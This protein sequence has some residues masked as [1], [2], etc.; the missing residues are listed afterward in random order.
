MKI[1]QIFSITSSLI[2]YQHQP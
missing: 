1:I 2:K